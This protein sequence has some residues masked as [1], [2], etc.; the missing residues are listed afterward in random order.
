[1]LPLEVAINAAA[2]LEREIAKS[3]VVFGLVLILMLLFH[4]VFKQEPKK[5]FYNF[6]K[7]GRM[8]WL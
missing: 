6:F 2:S 3:T 8:Q 1:V 7:E 4:L 5:L